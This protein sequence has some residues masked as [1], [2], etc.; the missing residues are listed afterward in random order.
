ML[1]GTR[2]AGTSEPRVDR[3]GGSHLVHRLVHATSSR[4]FETWRLRTGR[5][6]RRMR[7]QLRAR[8]EIGLYTF[9]D[10]TPDPRTGRL[11][12]AQQR[13]EEILAAAKLADDAGLNVFG[14][15][16]HH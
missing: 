15:G 9:G 16:E 2:Q 5:R 10:L 12:A 1:G 3:R 8:M 7:Q 4:S 13:Y 6:C 11:I 14:V